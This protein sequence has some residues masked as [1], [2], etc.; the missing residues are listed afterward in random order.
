[1]ELLFR[2]LKMLLVTM[3]SFGVEGGIKMISFG[4]VYNLTEL[5]N[6][7]ETNDN[8]YDHVLSRSASEDKSVI[9]TSNKPSYSML[10]FNDK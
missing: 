3:I 10:Y 1:M 8:D 4:L 6:S 2:V 7:A 9:W 5:I